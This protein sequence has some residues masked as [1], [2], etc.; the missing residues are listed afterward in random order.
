MK[1]L[2]FSQSF[3]RAYKTFIKRNP[4]LQAKIAEKL[5]LLAIDPYH[6]SLRTHKLKGQLSGA[7]ACSIEYD[8]RLIFS[9]TRN[10]ETGEEEILLIDI[11]THDEVY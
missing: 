3:K 5:K 4:D 10:P 11:G 8:C 2:V 7:W 1:T 6:A 9:F